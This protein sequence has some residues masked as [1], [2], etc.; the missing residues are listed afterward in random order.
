MGNSVE[1]EVQSGVR[2]QRVNNNSGFYQPNSGGFTHGFSNSVEDPF[3]F[4]YPIQQGNG[5]GFRQ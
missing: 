1:E 5:F 3:G 4:R 2:T